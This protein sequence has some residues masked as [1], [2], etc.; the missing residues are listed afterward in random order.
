MIRRT[1]S[2]TTRWAPS[3]CRFQNQFFVEYGLVAAGAAVTALPLL[4][5]FFVFQRR[6][7]TAITL[8]GLKG[9]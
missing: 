8:T 9:T 3:A 4:L 5:V 6:I 7:I 1:A 2:S